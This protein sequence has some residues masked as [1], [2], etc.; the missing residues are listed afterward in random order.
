MA[1]VTDDHGTWD[2][3]SDYYASANYRNR[4]DRWRLWFYRR[5]I[6]GINHRVER[7]RAAGP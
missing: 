5:L 6:G 2:D 4:P 7:L 1:A 3:P